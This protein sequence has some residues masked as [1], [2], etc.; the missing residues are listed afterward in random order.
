VALL[1]VLPAALLYPCMSFLLFEPDEGRYAEIPREMLVRGEWLVPYL[2]GEPYLDKPPLLYWLVVGSYRVLGVHDWAARLI[3]ALAVHGCILV[4]YLLGRRHLGERA[5]FWGALALALAPGFTS[6]GRLLVL[7]GLLALWVV[8][9]L[10]AAFEAV[11]RER[12]RWNWW[13]VAAL[14]CGLGVL[15]KGPVAG[16]LLLPPFL[17]YRWLAGNSCRIGGKGW[18]AFAAIA[19]AVCLPWYLA[20]CLRLPSFASHF[21]WKHNIVRFLNPFDHQEPVWFYGPIVVAGLLPISLLGIGFVRFLFSGDWQAKQVRCP[22]LGYQLLAAG[23]CVLF[24]S[25][26]GSKLPT[27]VLPA[28][29]GFALALG[30]FIAHSL[31]Q[32]SFWTRGC[33]GFAL[34]LLGALHYYALPWY[35]HFHSPMSRPEEVRSYCSDPAVPVVCYP[36]NCDSVAF[37]LGRADLRSYRS[38]ETGALVGFLQEHP[39]TVLLFTHRHSPDSLRHALP[40]GYRLTGMTPISKSWAS[41]FRTELC[42]MGMV[43]RE[44]HKDSVPP[45]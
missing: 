44:G 30:Y 40:A 25:I 24:F 9:S 27:Y 19:L 36:R 16:L 11:Q 23:W 35:A 7:D 1:L 5:A 32:V 26:S 34:V 37:Y 18:L 45:R 8:L 15:T 13:L 20:V 31:W 12:L 22:A 39:R 41:A 2:Q 28:F 38:K 14:A 33:A 42:Y 29:P 6:I 43:E 10:F 21:L 4:T 3:P 17:I